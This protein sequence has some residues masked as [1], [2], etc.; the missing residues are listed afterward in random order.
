LFATPP[1]RLPSNSNFLHPRTQSH[2]RLL[3][4]SLLSDLSLFVAGPFLSPLRA[5][6]SPMGGIT[7]VDAFDG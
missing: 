5:P 4:L 3:S 1:P 2:S 7:K 6:H